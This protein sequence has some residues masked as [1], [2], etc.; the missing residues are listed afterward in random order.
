M[1]TFDH[2]SIRIF[3]ATPENPNQIHIK[4]EMKNPQI[5]LLEDQQNPNSDCLVLDVS[6]YEISLKTIILYFDSFS[7]GS[8]TN[9]E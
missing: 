4:F 3:L 1:I 8:S 6:Q 9:N 5:I 2:F 7:V